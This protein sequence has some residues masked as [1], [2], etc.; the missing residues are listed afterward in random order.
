MVNLARV[1]GQFFV[2]TKDVERVV[3]FLAS[4][5]SLQGV[6]P[7]EHF[8]Q[9]YDGAKVEEQI[10]KLQRKEPSSLQIVRAAVGS[11][12]DASSGT[13]CKLHHTA[14]RLYCSFSVRR[15]DLVEA[16]IH[17]LLLH[18]KALEAASLF[19]AQTEQD[20]NEIFAKMIDGNDGVD[21]LLLAKE[22][23]KEQKAFFLEQAMFLFAEARNFPGLIATVQQMEDTTENRKLFQQLVSK[24]KGMGYTPAELQAAFSQACTPA[25]LKDFI[26]TFLIGEFLLARNFKTAIALA[27]N[28]RTP[29]R[30]DFDLQRVV[31]VLTN[32]GQLK[33]HPELLEEP[34]RERIQSILKVG[35]LGRWYHGVT[36]PFQHQIDVAEALLS[37]IVDEQKKQ[38]CTL[39][40]AAAKKA[41]VK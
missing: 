17:Q 36:V 15:E 38:E 11:L 39:L 29:A 40:V 8:W 4:Y 1:V 12:Q 24:L 16:T 28:L 22:L 20:Q 26:D 21:M 19:L 31:R 6:D 27:K 30:K 18:K 5:Q 32:L 33:T 35:A 41:I 2:P 3:A 34:T 10:A 13:L 9:G 23:P 14:T 7:R 25:F 37:E